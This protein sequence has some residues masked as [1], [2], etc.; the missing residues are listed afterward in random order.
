MFQIMQQLSDI[1]GGGHFQELIGS[2][3]RWRPFVEYTESWRRNYRWEIQNPVPNYAYELE[4]KT[5][6]SVHHH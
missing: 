1:C 5:R 6:K 3:Y 2:R 4:L